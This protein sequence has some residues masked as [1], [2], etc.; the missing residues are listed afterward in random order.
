MMVQDEYID[1]AEAAL[2]LGVTPETVLRRIRKG[3]LN[4]FKRDIGKGYLVDAR[5]IEKMK[6]VR[7]VNSEEA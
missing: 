2:R 1:V 3:V 5:D 4:A 6:E 7:P